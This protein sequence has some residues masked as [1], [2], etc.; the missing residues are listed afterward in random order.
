MAKALLQ[1]MLGSRAHRA[2]LE[3]GLD[4]I[5]GR[6][7]VLEGFPEEVTL[8]YDPNA[9]QSSAEWNRL[10]PDRLV[11][12]GGSRMRAG[13]ALGQRGPPS[14]WNCKWLSP[15]KA[16]QNAGKVN[17]RL[18]RWAGAGPQMA[19]TAKLRGSISS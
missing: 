16:L 8:G 1:E 14:I 15:A 6:G 10:G 7:V 19:L 17:R 9:Q 3:L 12:K 5:W 2:C 11:R 18:K 13:K 4:Q